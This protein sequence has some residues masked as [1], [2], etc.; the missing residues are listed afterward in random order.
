MAD[1]VES[2]FGPS[3]FDI[4]QQ[5]NQQLNKSALQYAQMDPLQRA[6]GTMFQAGGMLAGPAA[7]A[8]GMQNPQIMQ[9]QIKDAMMAK[10]GDLSTAEG[11]KAKAAQFAAMGD[12]KTAMQLILMARKMEAEETDLALK[13][14]HADYYAKGGISKTT[15]PLAQ[16][17]AKQAIARN[18]A[19][20][21]GMA[22]GLK[23][24]QLMDFVEAQVQAMTDQWYEASGVER[25][26]L[27]KEPTTPLT[28]ATAVSNTLKVTEE[29][30]RA[31]IADALSRGDEE[32]AA[33]LLA[34]PV[35][36]GI[37]LPKSKAEVAGEVK[38]AETLASNNPAALSTGAQAR[39]HG[40]ESAKEDIK[41]CCNEFSDEYPQ[42]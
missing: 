27:P 28:S 42:D 25:P 18:D 5:Q 1:I 39:E 13:K 21:S 36:P 37:A 41:Q 23:G 34:F 16:L 40:G 8:M 10:G 35:T 29:Q 33:K 4:Q 30:K 15:N 12:Q 20:K 7:G 2:L 9:A 17:P 38:L 22:A 11:L 32:A 24:Q 19:M 6:A 3:M 14:A 31:M 26:E